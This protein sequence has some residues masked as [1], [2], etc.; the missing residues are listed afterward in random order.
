MKSSHSI[1]LQHINVKLLLKDSQDL[2]LDP[3]IPVFHNWIQGQVYDE[4]LLDVADYRHVHGGPGV[5]LIGHEADYSVDD[6]DGRLGV[7]YNR[8]A[9]VSGGNQDRLAQAALAVL[10][11][12]Q[13]LQ[14]DTRLNG[15]LHFNGQDIEIFV[16]DRLLA[17]NNEA[18]REALNAEFQAFSERLF[19]GSEYSLS[20]SDDP[21]RLRGVSL[22]ASQPVSVED[23]LQNLRSSAAPTVDDL[24][25]HGPSSAVHDY[26]WREDLKAAQG[27]D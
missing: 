7:R 5:V 16:N 1:E 14:E 26:D 3:V 15:K 23:L 25:K 20:F 27:A 6:T 22:R 2:D 9:V 19:G 12:C 4:L 10:T 11:A 21:R 24:A 13:R 17:P 18:T 8:K